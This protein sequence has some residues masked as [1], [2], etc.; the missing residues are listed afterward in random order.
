M[1]FPGLNGYY[2]GVA[3]PVASLRGEGDCGI[4][5]FGDLPEFGRLCRDTGLHVLQILP[6]NDTGHDSSPYS[7]LSAYALHPV[8]VHLQTLPELSDERAAAA[9]APHI[10][11][12][13]EAASR[14]VGI[15]YQ[16]VLSRKLAA[17]RAIFDSVSERIEHDHTLDDWITRNDW[18]K[19]YA[20]FRM[21]KDMHEQAAWWQWTELHNPTVADIESRWADPANTPTLRFYAWVQMRLEEQLLAAAA[22]LNAL[23]VYLKGDLPILMNEDSADV[24]LHRDIFRLE[25]RAGA[26]P[27]M[28]SRFG[29]NWGFPVYNWKAME[30]NDY[31]WWRARL[32]QA[33]KFFH[34]FRIDHVLGFFRIWA[35]PEEN[36]TGTMGFF[37]PDRYFTW[38]ELYDA[39]FGDARIRWL[40]EPHID[41]A[42]IEAILGEQTDDIISRV[43]S[44]IGDEDMY[45][46]SEDV[47][48]ELKLKE[49]PLDHERIIGLID[50]YGDRALV[51]IDDEHFAPAWSFRSCSRYQSLPEDERDAFE[52][53]VGARAEESE[54]LWEQH[55][56]ALLG[57]MQ[58]EVDMLPCAE[59]LGVVPACVPQVLSDL[60]ILG[61]RVPR[62]ARK[63]DEPGQPF[64]RPQEYLYLTVCA[65]SVHDTTT[66]RGWWYEDPEARNLFWEALGFSDPAPD[67]YTPE[68][69]RR[70]MAALSA[71]ASSAITMFEIQDFFALTDDLAPDNPDDERIN[72]PGTY[73]SAN[74][75]YRVPDSTAALRR[76]DTLTEG[77]RYIA[78]S[79]RE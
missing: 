50:L 22:E 51:Q 32:R 77:M 79:R 20:V 25:L 54:R 73:N 5:E 4:G 37:S 55:G 11:M 58:R 61:L 59:D 53:L 9:A 19:P 56:R 69:A 8:Y 52:T 10:E 35:V 78:S 49:L 6:I 23:G 33:D 47:E 62:W 18:V 74:W 17:L 68:V 26:P 38:Q 63:W 2:T 70:V 72:V 1:K 67:R 42:G 29:Q 43:F 36:E 28:F 66:L 44:R 24:W 45:T 7:A 65:A 30:A 39:G 14:A 3:V 40:S 75:S 13:R 31:S 27:D 48:G 57:F 41:R 76:H 64:T 15:Q 71:S 60:G 34:L 21:L 46:F 16:D 12:L